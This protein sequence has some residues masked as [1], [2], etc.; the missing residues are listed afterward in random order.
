MTLTASVQDAAV[1]E[2]AADTLGA[3]PGDFDRY[4]AYQLWVTGDLFHQGYLSS[5]DLYDIEGRLR[6]HFG[7]GLPPLEDFEQARDPLDRS[8]SGL[9]VREEEFRVGATRQRVVHAEIPIEAKG[10]RLGTVIGHVLDEPENLPF[11]PQVAPYLASLGPGAPRVAQEDPA[12][13]PGYVLYDKDGDVLVSTLHQ[14][15]AA[16]ETLRNPA[17][18]NRTVRIDSG[19]EAYVGLPVPDGGRLH[20][21]LFPSFT[22]LERL[23]AFIRLFLLGLLALAGLL[24]FHLGVR[25]IDIRALVEA[26]RRSF[27]RKLLA[28]VLLVSVV[29]VIGLS[30]FLRGYVERQAEAGLV[31]SAAGLVSVVQRVVADYVEVQ[32]DTP[33]AA[34]PRLTDEILSWLRRVVKLEIHLYESG[35]LT[36]SSK[37]E[38]FASGL[39]PTRIPGEVY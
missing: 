28:T 10:V 25:G 23:G 20:L 15:P 37:R 12:G 21:L 5:I 4:A 9:E 13:A 18:E 29:P 33:D 39:L 30:V 27:Y 8:R 38:L 6:S 17:A 35:W 26:V 36:A 31:E 16:S 22:L 11:L 32:S 24:V 34:L 3:P 2:P 1:A 7:F 14:P 19:E